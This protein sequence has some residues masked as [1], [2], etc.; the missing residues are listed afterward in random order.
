VVFR[1]EPLRS[2]SEALSSKLRSVLVTLRDE[3]NIFRKVTNLERNFDR[4]RNR[5]LTGADIQTPNAYIQAPKCLHTSA[6]NA[7]I[8]DEAPNAYIQAPNA[9]ASTPAVLPPHRRRTPAA[10]APHSRRTGAAQAPRAK[11]RTWTS[12][13][14][15]PGQLNGNPS[16]A[17]LSGKTRNLKHSLKIKLF[18][19]SSQ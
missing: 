11:R 13:P 14:Q 15:T 10:E 6:K 12:T 19:N 16:P 7:N 3:S 1:S 2:S 18:T 17:G 8:N 4:T 5:R 9:D